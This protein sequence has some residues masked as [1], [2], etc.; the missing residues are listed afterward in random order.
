MK[1]R[2]ARHQPESTDS[3]KKYTQKRKKSRKARD[4]KR[5]RKKKE[6]RWELGAGS[7]G[8]LVC[9]F[10][11]RY[12]KFYFILYLFSIFHH[13]PCALRR[14]VPSSFAL[15]HGLQLQWLPSPSVPPHTHTQTQTQTNKAREAGVLAVCRLFCGGVTSLKLK[16][17]FGGFT[18]VNGVRR[19]I[20]KKANKYLFGIIVD[21]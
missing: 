1:T 12:E 14:A 19:R 8:V 13:L 9:F 21:C 18:R 16:N 6:R 3:Q 2:Q 17:L 10:L 20:E 4:G 5:E 7:W 15:L 11:S